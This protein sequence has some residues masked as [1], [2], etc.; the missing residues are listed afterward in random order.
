MELMR[1]LAFLTS[2]QNYP[3]AK[4]PEQMWPLPWDK[5]AKNVH[6]EIEELNEIFDQL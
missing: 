1:T 6:Q 4:R 2:A 5:P 3:K